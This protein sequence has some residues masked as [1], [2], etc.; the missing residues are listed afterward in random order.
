MDSSEIEAMFG[1]SAHRYVTQYFVPEYEGV[2]NDSTL[3]VI[4]SAELKDAAFLCSKISDPEAAQL[5]KH[6]HDIIRTALHAYAG[7]EVQHSGHGFLAYFNLASEA[8]N[9]G[10]EILTNMK[11]YN[12]RHVL[13]PVFVQIG[14]STGTPVDGHEHIFGQAVQLANRL[15]FI[16]FNN[17]LTISARV[18]EIAGQPEMDVATKKAFIRILSLPDEKFLNHLL[19]S[20]EKAT[21][22]SKVTVLDFA[23][24]LGMSKSKLYRK[25]VAL[26]GFS[27][28]NFLKEFRL[29]KAV[30]LIESREGN[31][32][33]ISYQ[34]GFTCPSYFCK[35]FLKRFNTL[36]SVFASAIV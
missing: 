22:N 8:L 15:R 9:C 27:P 24:S 31:I 28:N 33:E 13:E 7:K 26:T 18:Q 29:N 5:I 36:P 16:D 17:R 35:C 12:L 14:I 34:V 3:R 21:M 1:K 11:A 30:Q 25:T 23:R 6:T 10:L 4:M 20:I 2:V 19:D 32:S